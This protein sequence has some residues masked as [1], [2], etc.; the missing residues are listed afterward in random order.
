[1]NRQAVTGRN[2][3]FLS[4]L[5]CLSYFTSYLT[6]LNYSACLIE[7][8]A[9]LQL[10]KSQAGLPVTGFFLVYGIGQLICGFLGDKAAPHK[11]IFIGL[12]GTSACNFLIVLFPHIQVITFLWI[13][14][15]FFQSMLWPP[16]VRMMAELLDETWYRRCSV[17]VSFAASLG[18][19]VI[20]LLT[21]ACLSV[22]GW[23]AMFLFPAIAGFG[24]AFYWIYFTQDFADNFVSVKNSKNGWAKEIKDS[25][26][27]IAYIV[28]I[29]QILAIIALHG[30][31]KDGITTWMPAYMTDSFGMST[32]MSV[33]TTAVLPVFSIISTFFTSL[34]YDRI[35]DE[36]YTT[37]VLFGV[38]LAAGILMVWANGM[39]PVWCMIFMMLITGCMFGAN[40]MLISRMPRHFTGFGTV[41]TISGILNAATYAGSALSTYGFGK[42]AES[43]GW[44]QVIGLWIVVCISA[45]FLLIT[46]IRKWVNFSQMNEVNFD[47]N[48]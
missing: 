5:F 7:I 6:R 27:R 37:I 21:P 23:K 32:S 42:I 33:L 2:M 16:L 29:W 28:P 22:W 38:S 35:H 44:T 41:S 17:L 30:V 24:V 36:L 11:I 1:M 18:T 31:L 25:L 20:Y 15:G 3:P 9:A 43:S 8:Q 4:F 39:Y 48:I 26:A 47:L 40:L 13:V 45:I 14:N 19:I 10:S 12:T 34:L 46:S